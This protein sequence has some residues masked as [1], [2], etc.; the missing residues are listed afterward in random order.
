MVSSKQK[1]EKQGGV[2][3]LRDPKKISVLEILHSVE[4]GKTLFNTSY[5]IM[6][7]GKRPDKAQQSVSELFGAAE[8]MM[9]NV[10][11]GKSVADIL[12]DM[13]D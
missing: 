9:A 5:N 6:A 7:E 4:K 8:K 2:R 3:L 11:A 13:N 10:L 12:E 1:K